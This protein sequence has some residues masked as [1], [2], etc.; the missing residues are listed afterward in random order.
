MT[1]HKYGVIQATTYNAYAAIINSIYADTNPGATATSIADFG[2]GQ[3][4]DIPMI[5]S[6]NSITAAQWTTLFSK[7]HA[8]GTHQ[9]T[10]VSPIPISVSAGDL[11]AAYNDYLSTQTLTDV[12][13]LLI[14]NRLQVSLA[15]RSV[16]T[17]PASPSSPAWT[18][19][20]RYSFTIDFGS[21]D[22]ARYF[23]NTGGAV[24]FAGTGS[25]GTP[26]DIFWQTMLANMGVL[27]V[28]WHDTIPTTGAGSTTGFY[29][30]SDT[31]Y[32]KIWQGPSYTPGV[33]SNSYIAI[34]G[35]LG[36]VAGTSGIVDF[37]I[38]LIDNDIT[39]DSKSASTISYQIGL[40]QSSGTIPYPGPTVSTGTGTFLAIPTTGITAI[41]LTLTSSPSTLSASVVDAAV[42]TT[43]PVTVVAAGGTAPYTY[44]WTLVTG[45]ATINSPTS[46]TTTF[47]KL[48]T[49]GEIISGTAKCTV[50]DSLS[51]VSFVL[52]NWSMN[53]NMSNIPGS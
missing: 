22:N 42:A 27:Q 11:I 20:L 13:S 25:S 30:L 46:S 4:P 32:T 26:V 29:D 40:L 12:I 9:G 10:S 6:G 7:I 52:I 49:A 41:P 53:S 5:T 48:L 3:L 1:Y 43:S 23:F 51:V 14:A 44:A 35:Q 28:I 38:E 47:S 18:T 21:W 16:V 24:T 33:Y 19:G 36:A 15:Q 45:S 34:Y 8:C 37:R 39:P 50:T 17:S 2:Y 31:S